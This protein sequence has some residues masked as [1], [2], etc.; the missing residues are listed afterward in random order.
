MPT[1]K[2]PSTK[3]NEVIIT[4]TEEQQEQIKKQTGKLVNVLKLTPQELEDRANPA[5]G[6]NVSG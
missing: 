4:L 3:P 5:M 2:E 6:Y 1:E